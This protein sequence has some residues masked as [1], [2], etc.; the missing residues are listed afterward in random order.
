MI[1]NKSYIGG[2]TAL[3]C[4]KLSNPSPRN[5]ASQAARCLDCLQKQIFITRHRK[6]TFILFYAPKQIEL[7]TQPYKHARLK[8]LIST[9]LFYFYC[10]RFGADKNAI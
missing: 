7:Q 8:R 4:Y 10:D 5:G 6:D 9:L 3:C 2:V 1:P